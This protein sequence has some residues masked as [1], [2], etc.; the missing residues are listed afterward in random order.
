MNGTVVERIVCIS[1][2]IYHEIHCS[3]LAVDECNSANE[4][5]VVPVT[6]WLK[7]LSTS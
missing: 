4:D 2:N 3:K 7:F 6:M 1:Y 5:C